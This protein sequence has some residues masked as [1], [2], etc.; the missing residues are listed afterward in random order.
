M[1]QAADLIR[2]RE[3]R[4]AVL[5]V[6]GLAKS[7][8]VRGGVF[9]RPVAQV[10]AVDDV[11]FD[12]Y[13]GEVLGVVGESGCGK[14]TV[15][16]LILHLEQP[17]RGEIFFNDTPVG[18]RHGLTLRAL[19]R[20]VQMVFQDSHAALNPR[21]TV[22]ET[23]AYGPLSTGVQRPLAYGRTETLLAD[24]GL[25]P[26]RFADRYPHELSGGQ[27]QRVNIARALALAP[28]VVILDE[29]VS[30][31]DK[32]VGAQILNLLVRLKREHDL[33]YIF[34]SHDLNVVEYLADRVLVMYL[35]SIVELGATDTILREPAH[36]YTRALIAS[37]PT[38]DPRRRTKELPISGDLPNPM[39][40]PSGCRF[41]TRCPFAETVCATAPPRL[42]EL[43]RSKSHSVA[44][45]IKDPSSGHSLA[46]RDAPVASGTARP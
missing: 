9:G 3:H 24:V 43:D 1:S 2:S 12:L 28:K 21:M 18:G 4:P 36:P 42:I 27:R 15:A 6:Q 20:G 35:G 8:A 38:V 34:I 7:F 26:A 29:A 14:S 45:H 31:L 39:D 44:C 19:R 33:Q 10:H 13:P 16:R 17:D 5:R 30:A 40:P 37:Q 41:R 25:D 46:S 11:S 22:F 32:S 23:I